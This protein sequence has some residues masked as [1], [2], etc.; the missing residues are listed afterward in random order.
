MQRLM[1]LSQGNTISTILQY[2]IIQ[3]NIKYTSFIILTII[4]IIIIIITTTTTT[5]TII[6]IMIGFADKHARIPSPP[7]F[8][9]SCSDIPQIVV[10]DKQKE[11]IHD[12]E[13]YR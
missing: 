8:S 1:R 4:I 9:S 11:I 6:I 2:N 13:F 10:D 12:K 3:Y 7:P 5:T